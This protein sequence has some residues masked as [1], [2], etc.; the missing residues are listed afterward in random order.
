MD[1][2]ST[3]ELQARIVRTSEQLSA[4][5]RD[6]RTLARRVLKALQPALENAIRKEAELVGRP[7]AQQIKE[8]D[9]MLF[10]RRASL[11]DSTDAA[12]AGNGAASTPMVPESKPVTPAQTGADG[13][14]EMA[15]AD[16]ELGQP[17]ACDLPVLEL[18]SGDHEATQSQSQMKV[19]PEGRLKGPVGLQ[20]PHHE[21]NAATVE[22][23]VHTPP[24]STNGIKPD[25]AVDT[26]PDT[27]DAPVVEPPTPPLSFEGN[28]QA[29]LTQGGIGW[30]VEQFDPEGTTIYDERWT[31][32]EVLR[33]MSEELSEMDDEELEELAGA[34]LT[35]LDD[36]D[37]IVG[38]K[39]DEM[40][41]TASPTKKP[42]KKNSKQK[43]GNDWGTRSFRNRRW[44]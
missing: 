7:Y 28:Q 21:D 19:K 26:G 24:A 39:P 22:G 11:T 25:V 20:A 4:E 30:Y 5:E 18:A 29:S 37:E 35:N 17:R 14:V 41:L 40:V 1:A 33:E 2:T 16:S 44:R 32:P 34:D 27:R 8:M 15:E 13:D 12:I 6:R 3:A 31:G 10:S 23:S 36:H 43:R 42:T 9:A 38:A